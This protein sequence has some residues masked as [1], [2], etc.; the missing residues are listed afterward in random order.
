MIFFDK[1]V[2]PPTYNLLNF[3]AICHFFAAQLGW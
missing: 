3:T 2:N 1:Y